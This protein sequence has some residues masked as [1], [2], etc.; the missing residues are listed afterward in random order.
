MEGW[1][2]GIMERW[3]GGMV[4]WWMFPPSPSMGEGWGEGE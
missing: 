3:N 2:Y 1:N 4:E